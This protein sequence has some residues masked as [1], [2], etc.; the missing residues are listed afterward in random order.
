MA[1]VML[2]FKGYCQDFPG[3]QVVK[4]ALANAWDTGWIPDL[5]AMIPHA[6]T[7]LSPV[8]HRY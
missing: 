2:S 4:K 6:L 8:S 3:G 7:Q 5:G 1:G